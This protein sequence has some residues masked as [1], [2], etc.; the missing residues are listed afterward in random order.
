MNPEFLF[1][2]SFFYLT[3]TTLG[4]LPPHI[5]V[6]VGATLLILGLVVS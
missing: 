2:A 3:A 5:A 4:V 1:W 6:I